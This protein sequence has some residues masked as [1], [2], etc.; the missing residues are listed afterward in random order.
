M[1]ASRLAMSNILW[2]VREVMESNG[3]SSSSYSVIYGYPNEEKVLQFPTITI[4]KNNI[5]YIGIELTAKDRERISIVLDIFG[6]ADSQRDDITDLLCEYFNQRT[7]VMYDFTTG[8]PT[9]VGDY[10]GI[11]RLGEMYV[12][13]LWATTLQ[14][15][16]FVNIDAKKYHDM[17]ILDVVL[18]TF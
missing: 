17:I 6:N 12:A 13:K 16:S 8:F 14:I 7:I 9:I 11:P 15:P 1:K 3:F 2:R 5:S 18:P 4:S 10:S